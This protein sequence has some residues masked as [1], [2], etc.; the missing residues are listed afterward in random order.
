VLGLALKLTT[1]GVMLCAHSNMSSER[2]WLLLCRMAGL[3]FLVGSVRC[4]GTEPYLAACPS[5]LQSSCAS[6]KTAVIKCQGEG[7]AATGWNMQGG[8]YILQE[9]A[10]EAGLRAVQP[11]DSRIPCCLAGR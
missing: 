2:H 8:G 4:A 9:R 11:A 6:G 3:K 7:A 5:K 1:F 10:A